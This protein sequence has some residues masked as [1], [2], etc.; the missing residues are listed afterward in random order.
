[1]D[2]TS[3]IN[4]LERLGYYKYTADEKINVLKKECLEGGYAFGWEETCRDFHA[5]AEDLA[6]GGISLFLTEIEPF[7]S[8]QGIRLADIKESFDERG[9]TIE[10]NGK[11][12]VIY[13][14]QEL[15]HKDI[16][17]LATSRTI[18]IINELLASTNERAYILYGGN[19]QRVIFLT[20]AMFELIQVTTL[21][22]EIEKPLSLEQF[23]A[24][25]S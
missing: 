23:N 21:I 8:K 2:I 20:S 17:S 25:L 3:L 6:E 13:D 18:E 7:L 9:S 11:R 14:Q 5:D 12:S 19:D 1:M 4:D 15:K 22:E 24:T 10:I 16:W